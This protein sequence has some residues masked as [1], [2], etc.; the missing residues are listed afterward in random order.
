MHQ[1]DFC[2]GSSKSDANLHQDQSTGSVQL[3]DTTF[4]SKCAGGLRGT[5][6]LHTGRWKCYD[7]QGAV[8]SEQ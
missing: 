2:G 6:Q 8:F 1:T 5:Y 4:T 7:S 3:G